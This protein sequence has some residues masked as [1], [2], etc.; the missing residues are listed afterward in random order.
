MTLILV[1]NFIKQ[2][3]M[4]IV[5]TAALGLVAAWHFDAIHKAVK[6]NDLEWQAKNKIAADAWAVKL[7][8][9]NNATHAK[10]AEFTQVVTTITAAHEKENN[11]AN[12][13]YKVALSRIATGNLILYDKF[14]T[15]QCANASKTETQT[16]TGMGNDSTGCRLSNITTEYL[17]KRAIKADEIVNESNAVKAL[18]VETY[19]VCSN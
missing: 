18:L 5:I 11:D 15:N 19:K 13:K 10:E 16:I 17:V 12:E 9:A 4:P 14:A 1:W 7:T 6:A 8:E 3:W 2:F